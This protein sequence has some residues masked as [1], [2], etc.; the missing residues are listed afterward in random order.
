MLDINYT[1]K[2]T[3]AG[4]ATMSVLSDG[5]EDVQ[6]IAATCREVL[7]AFNRAGLLRG[8]LPE[9][10]Q[11]E[12]GSEPAKWAQAALEQVTGH[13]GATAPLCAVHKK[14][15]SQQNGK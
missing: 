10:I 9:G 11:V 12:Q 1:V 2:I 5:T 13:T 3:S 4:E 14:P 15:M 6:D 8:E 7:Q